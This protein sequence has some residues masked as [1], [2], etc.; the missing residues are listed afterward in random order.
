MGRPFWALIF[1]LRSFHLTF[2]AR[3]KMVIS[4]VVFC[5]WN[6]LL[7][8]ILPA[9]EISNS[10]LN[11]GKWSSQTLSHILQIAKLGPEPSS[12][13]P[14]SQLLPKLSKTKW[15]SCVKVHHKF[16]SKRILNIVFKHNNP[17]RNQ[18][19]NAHHVTENAD[20]CS[21]HTLQHA[22]SMWGRKGC[23]QGNNNWFLGC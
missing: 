2:L 10:F 20:I 15:V 14:M 5:S 9:C 7:P 23:P 1:I 18:L 8:F 12:T 19:K 6:S 11:W 13:L 22:F 4:S 3:K 21:P 17:S 16:S